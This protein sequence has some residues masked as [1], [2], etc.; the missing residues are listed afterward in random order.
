MSIVI[1]FVVVVGWGGE[2]STLALPEGASME[3]IYFYLRR[4]RQVMGRVE[5]VVL[6]VVLVV[7]Q[8]SSYIIQNWLEVRLPPISH[9]ELIW[10]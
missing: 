5:I 1:V 9:F 3:K 4:S 8:A 6:V 10:R 2:G 7:L